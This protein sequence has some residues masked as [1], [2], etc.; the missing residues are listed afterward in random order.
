[1]NAGKAFKLTCLGRVTLENGLD[2]IIYSDNQFSHAVLASHYCNCGFSTTDDDEQRAENYSDWCMNGD[3][4]LDDAN[5]AK[6]AKMLGLTCIH[7]ASGCCDLLEV[8]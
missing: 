7:S 8:Y 3:Q 1:M 6:A 4:F 2:V 5:A